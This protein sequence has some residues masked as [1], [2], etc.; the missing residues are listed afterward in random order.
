MAAARFAGAPS[1]RSS[2]AALGTGTGARGAAE[3]LATRTNVVR[4]P[5]RRRRSPSASIPRLMMS[6]V[7]ASASSSTS[8]TVMPDEDHS[9][10]AWRRLRHRRGEDHAKYRYWCVTNLTSRI[11][12]ALLIPRRSLMV[13]SRRSAWCV[14]GPVVVLLSS[15]SVRGQETPAPLEAAG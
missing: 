7:V 13:L 9:R 3:T 5:C 1:I 12:S 15:A 11:Y 6:W 2:P 10:F 4:V 8:D 14:V